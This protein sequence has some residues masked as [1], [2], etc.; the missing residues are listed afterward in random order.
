MLDN[1]T[2]IQR[3]LSGLVCYSIKCPLNG[4]H[5]TSNALLS[6]SPFWDGGGVFRLM[7]SCLFQSVW[8]MFFVVRSGLWAVCVEYL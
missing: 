2:L 3:G 4:I 5:L 6:I 1:I 7:K 8:Y